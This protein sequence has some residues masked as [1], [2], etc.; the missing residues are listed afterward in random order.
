MAII[1]ALQIGIINMFSEQYDRK[2]TMKYRIL[3]VDHIL[4]DYE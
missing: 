2:A 4:N 1:D 3:P